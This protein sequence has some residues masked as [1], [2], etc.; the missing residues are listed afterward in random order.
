[1]KNTLSRLNELAAYGGP[2][3]VTCAKP[4]YRWPIIGSEEEEIILELLRGGEISI[5]G[6]SGV[7]AELENAF[8]KFCQR[9]YAL[10]MNSGT[11]ALFAAYFA[12]GLRPGDEVIV[13]TYTFPA[14]VTPLLHFPARVVLCDADPITGNV[15]SDAIEQCLSSRTAA[16]V[17]THMWGLPCQMDK[18]VPLCEKHGLTLIEDASHALGATFNGQLVG[19]F[20]K[21]ACISLQGNKMACAGE[22]GMLIT[23][24]VE[25]YDR[26]TLFA[27]FRKRPKETVTTPDLI[28]YWETGFGLKLKMHPLAAAIAI[29][30]LEKTSKW[31]EGRHSRLNLLSRMLK[32]AKGIE[33]P[34]ESSSSFRGA[35]YGYKPLFVSEQL[36]NLS[37]DEY[38]RLLQAEGLD[39]HKPGTQPLHLTPLFSRHN[40]PREAWNFSKKA[41]SV[42]SDVS[43]TFPG[44][45]SYYSRAVSVPTFTTEPIELAEAYGLAFQKV[46]EILG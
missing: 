35:W 9:R 15:T 3:S 24:D 21:A 30:Q 25:I 37:L 12:I 18:I 46:G 42:D 45:E 16:V 1:M 4:H 20:G 39:I 32:E 13:P 11:S 27:N 6:R 36:D 28:D 10:S 17:I 31:I 44:A 38:L 40:D 33:P 43:R 2:Q 26:A 22:G 7:I 23:N 14:T 29:K 19:T 8:A 5:Y 41:Y 34:I